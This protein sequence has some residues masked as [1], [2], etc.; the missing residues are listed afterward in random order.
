MN[1]VSRSETL[2]LAFYTHKYFV[3]NSARFGALIPGWIQLPPCFEDTKLPEHTDVLFTLV[4]HSLQ[5]LYL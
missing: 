4:Q 1:T 2:Q 3:I 5:K